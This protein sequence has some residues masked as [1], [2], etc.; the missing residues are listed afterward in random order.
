MAVAA[1][2]AGLIFVR[3]ALRDP[4]EIIT[5]DAFT[6]SPELLGV[7]LARPSRRLIAIA[8]D[9]IC[10]AILSHLGG[11]VLLALGA[12]IMLWR[13]ASRTKTATATT[14]AGITTPPAAPPSGLVRSALRLAS[15]MALVIFVWTGYTWVSDRTKGLRTAVDGA[16]VSAR[17]SNR[18]ADAKTVEFDFKKYGIGFRD[19]RALML[20]SRFEDAAD[21]A[22]A[23]AYADSIAAWIRTKPD[24][25]QAGIALGISNMLADASGK[26]ALR[27]SLAPLLPP[28]PANA[29]DSTAR[30][31]A[32]LHNAVDS[33][34][35]RNKTLEKNYET[36]TEGFSVRRLLKSI[37]NVL[38]FGLGWSA[39][40]FTAF[41][42][43]MRGQTP[44]KK[45]FGIRVIRLDGRPITG[46]IAF[47]RFGGYAAS[48][49]TGLLG[50]AQ[51]LWDSNR[52]G[53]HDKVAGT[54]VI[55][56]KGGAPT[57]PYDAIGG[58][59]IRPFRTPPT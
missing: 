20:I 10:V 12:G 11:R 42:M 17:S 41:T 28:P 58:A 57:R 54:V 5:P 47:E 43:L 6:V 8:V 59:Q 52:Q 21:S 32:Q 55:R 7:G 31:I 18:G 22:A 19:A 39:L 13:S 44:G 33:L 2:H 3:M 30:E 56:E 53:I 24:S 29:A 25:A 51:I 48:A 49:A 37:S 27:A 9:G 1:R 50:F 38:G 36:A 4:R 23:V 34:A 35:K 40:Y 15:V 45:L 46:W 16:E 14:T 26:A